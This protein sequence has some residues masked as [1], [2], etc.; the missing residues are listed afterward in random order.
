MVSASLDEKAVP[1]IRR[2]RFA[3]ST[4][5]TLGYLVQHD[6]L[7]LYEKEFNLC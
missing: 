7:V 2:C 3:S 6:V 1:G 5:G 4:K